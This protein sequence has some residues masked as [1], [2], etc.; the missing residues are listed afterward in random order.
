MVEVTLQLTPLLSES[1][2]DFANKWHNGSLTT[3]LHAALELYLDTNARKRKQLKQ[4]VQQIRQEMEVRGGLDEKD[5]ERRISEYR[6]VK[7][8]KPA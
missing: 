8:S 6:R 3:V 4:V 7:Y 1:I 5:L 2:R